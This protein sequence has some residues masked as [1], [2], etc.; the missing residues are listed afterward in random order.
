MEREAIGR[1]GSSRLRAS[2]AEAERRLAALE[3]RERAW[4]PAVHDVA[5]HLVAIRFA[6]ESL[7]AAPDAGGAREDLV[8]ILA[9]AERA[10]EVLRKVDREADPLL[11]TAPVDAAEV[12]AGFAPLLECLA[13]PAARCAVRVARRPLPVRA[14]RLELEQILAHLAL[15]ARDA[16]PA[17]GRIE[18]RVAGATLPGRTSPR[19]FGAPPGRYARI[20]VRDEGPDRCAALRARLCAA[21]S[22]GP[23]AA[24]PGLA[25]VRALIADRFGGDVALE[26]APGGGTVVSVFLPL[27]DDSR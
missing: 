25:R 1:A 19:L 9:A 17:G 20:Q 8:V 21:P 22:P 2:L 3:A 5:N 27:A 14:S 16:T 23:T 6:T 18:V 10:S 24:A 15:D 26:P 4:R 12:V 13:H 11:R 7:L